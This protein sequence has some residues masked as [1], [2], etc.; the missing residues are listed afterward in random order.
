MPVSS[1]AQHSSSVSSVKSILCMSEPFTLV[2]GIASLSTV[3]SSFRIPLPFHS[4][5]YQSLHPLFTLP[6]QLPALP[7]SPPC[8]ALLLVYTFMISL[9]GCRMLFLFLVS[10]VFLSASHVAYGL[11]AECYLLCFIV[12]AFI[13]TAGCFANEPVRCTFAS[14]FIFTVLDV[15]LLHWCICITIF[16]PCWSYDT[17]CSRACV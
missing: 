2:K 8:V 10:C 6:Q 9:F 17:V 14:I 11:V 1:Y 4:G 12:P 5:R 3:Y 13:G 7:L 15:S 16:R